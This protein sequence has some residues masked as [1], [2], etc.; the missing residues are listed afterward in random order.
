MA[1]AACVAAD[2]SSRAIPPPGSSMFETAAGDSELA[3]TV[4]VGTVVAGRESNDG[5]ICD[6]LRDVADGEV[7]S[8][9]RPH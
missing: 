8:D 7:E 4:P 3:N 2:S 6:K 9:S 1:A 5:A